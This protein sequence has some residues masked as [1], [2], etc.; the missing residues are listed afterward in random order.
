MMSPNPFMDP[1]F[2]RKP[3]RPI[4]TNADQCWQHRQLI[5]QYSQSPQ[6]KF[7]QSIFP[8]F[9]FFMYIG[10]LSVPV[11]LTYSLL[12]K[13]KWYFAPLG[14][15]AICAFLAIPYFYWSRTKRI[16]NALE[17]L[18]T[19]FGGSFGNKRLLNILDWFDAHWPG[20]HPIEV[21]AYMSP[22]EDRWDWQSTFANRH[23][24]LT[25]HRNAFA[26]DHAGTLNPNVERM[27]FFLTSATKMPAT[28]DESHP[29][30]LELEKLGFWVKPTEAGLFVT[31]TG[32]AV[33]KLDPSYV[34]RVLELAS[35]IG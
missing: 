14:L 6:H 26:G 27:S 12:T 16:S 15:L 24:L 34:Q 25:V 22:L 2:Q 1:F 7:A 9:G 5:R 4:R 30:V 32:I 18:V 8:F 21:V 10:L 19:V 17:R 20:D 31:H 28:L 35:R 29:A 33:E 13:G 11:I 23:V 3:D